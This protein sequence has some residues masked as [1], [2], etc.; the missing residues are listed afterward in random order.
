MCALVSRSMY[1]RV[2]AGLCVRQSLCVR[3]GAHACGT[4]YIR[5]GFMCASLSV[6]VCASVCA[7]RAGSCGRTRGC[8]RA[9]VSVQPCVCVCA[10][11]LHGYRQAF[12]RICVF[13]VFNVPVC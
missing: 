12:S 10:G 3:A 1:E 9:R 11:F 6:S 13:K 7:L 2:R 4:V 8:V 5:C